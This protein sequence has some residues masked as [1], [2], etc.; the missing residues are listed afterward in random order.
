MGL[1][2][3][4]ALVAAQLRQGLSAEKVALAIALGMVIGVFPILGTTTAI[5]AIV[6]HF[7]RLNHALIQ[8]ANYAV[9]PAF[10]ALMIPWVRLGGWLFAS[11]VHA[12][13]LV[14]MRETYSHGFLYFVGRLSTELLHAALA[15]TLLAP[16]CVVLLRG[17][18]L[19]FIRRR[20]GDARHP[21]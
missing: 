8:A 10:I 13:T 20:F 4:R 6:A 12:L 7:L 21:V 5:C 15:W 18:L 11:E 2:K 3:V 1:N 16:L 14:G 17:V 19:V 9:Y